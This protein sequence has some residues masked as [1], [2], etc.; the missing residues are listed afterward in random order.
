MREVFELMES[1]AASP[2][3]VLIEG[4]TGTGKEL[5]ARGIHARQRRADGPVRRGQLRRACPRRCSRASSS[6]TSAARSP[7]RSQRPRGRLRGGRRRHA[8]PR[9]DR[10]DAARDA[11]EAPARRCRRARSSAGR[12]DATAPRRRPRDLRDEPHRSNRWSRAGQMRADLFYRLSAFPDLASAAA[13]HRRDDIPLFVAHFLR[14]A[15]TR[16]EREI[17]G[18]GPEALELLLHA[19]WP[20]NVRELRNEI[21][22][23]VALA[24][25]GETIGPRHLSERHR[26]GG[27]RQIP[28]MTNG[29][30]RNG[31][32]PDPELPDPVAEPDLRKHAPPSKRV[33]SGPCSVCT[34]ATSRTRRVR[35]G[36]RGRCSRRR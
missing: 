29:R 27:T 17:A 21:E 12:R 14:D 34:T 11:G 36:S 15:A 5:V 19:E 18:V 6:A 35:S 13:E 2:I 8:L 16:H 20:G 33:T 25:P 7:A 9:R 22:R 1:A 32:G 4:E 24:R 3:A 28:E 31:L 23:A 10:R 26:T 30:S